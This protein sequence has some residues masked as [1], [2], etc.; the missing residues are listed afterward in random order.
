MRWKCSMLII[1]AMLLSG[2]AAGCVSET[3]TPDP[4]SLPEPTVTSTATSTETPTSTPSP[5]QTPTETSTPTPEPSEPPAPTETPTS[6][7]EPDE[8]APAAPDTVL[9]VPTPTPEPSPTPDSDVTTEVKSVWYCEQQGD[10]SYQWYEVKVTYY[11]GTPVAETVLSGPYTGG[12]QPNCPGVVTAIPLDVSP[13]GDESI[14][15][16]GGS[17]GGDGD[18]ENSGDDGSGNSNDDDE[19]PGDFPEG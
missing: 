19:K 2:L 11:Q 7:P 14:G 15:G 5:T 16:G 3:A 8:A 1:G 17:S 9:R 12:W 13:S 4:T 18:N 10:G 6:V